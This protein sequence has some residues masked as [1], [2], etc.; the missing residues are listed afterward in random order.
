VSSAPYLV[1]CRR[2]ARYGYH[3][4]CAACAGN[5]EVLEWDDP[6]PERQLDFTALE[7]GEWNVRGVL[8]RARVTAWDEASR[9]IA[10]ALSFVDV[11]RRAGPRGCVRLVRTHVDVDEATARQVVH[12]WCEA[13]RE[14]ARIRESRERLRGQETPIE[15][16][17]LEAL[18]DAIDPLG[19]LP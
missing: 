12:T 19:G 4:D 16:F 14:L 7:R 9:R 13:L 17:E 8:A 11:A 10:Y 18:A 6:L 1:K 5:A 15:A 2:C 3:E